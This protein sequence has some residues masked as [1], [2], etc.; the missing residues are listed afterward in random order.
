MESK[1]CKAFKPEAPV[2][3]GKVRWARVL[4]DINDEDCPSWL[5]DADPRGR[6]QCPSA[7]S[8]DG[9]SVPRNELGEGLLIACL[10]DEERRSF[11]VIDPRFALAAF[12][13]PRRAAGQ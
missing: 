1:L 4:D 5:R 11:P 6:A 13:V 10:G 12:A 2:S 3:T 9:L 8:P 7:P